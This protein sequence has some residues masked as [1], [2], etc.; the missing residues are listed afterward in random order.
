MPY[1]EKFLR[2]HL[3]FDRQVVFKVLFPRPAASA[4]LGN[5]LEMQMFTF[6]PR[7]LTEKCM[8]AGAMQSVFYNLWLADTEF[9][10]RLE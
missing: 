7:L 9:S 10:T 8:E 6:Y 3:T 4:S 1:Y 5:W 2:F